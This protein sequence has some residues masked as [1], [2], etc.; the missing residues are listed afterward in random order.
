VRAETSAGES[1]GKAAGS[2]AG[3]A[4]A[5]GSG[6]NRPV[7]VR[8]QE[9]APLP[10]RF[11]TLQ[12][13]SVEGDDEPGIPMFDERSA[14]RRAVPSS[15]SL[16]F[17]A[18]A[19]PPVLASFSGL[20]SGDG[21]YDPPDPEIA[22]GNGSVVEM[23]NSEIRIW[24]TS[25]T[26]RAT[27]STATFFNSPSGDVTDPRIVYDPASGRWF[28]TVLDAGEDTV[29]LGISKTG[30]PNGSW[31]VYDHDPGLCADQPTLGVS[32]TLV[33][34]GY[35]GFPSPCRQSGEPSY[36]GG[37][38]YVYNKSQLLSGTTAYFTYWNPNPGYSPVSAVKFSSDPATAVVLTDISSLNVLSF[39]GLPN[40]SVN[41]SLSTTPIGIRSLLPPPDADQANSS[42]PINTGDIRFH[43]AAM[44]T[45]TGTTWLSANDGCVPQGDSTA[46]SCLRIIALRN[47]GDALDFDVAWNG[48]DL[49]Y[50][51]ISPA[52]AGSA[53]VVNGFSSSSTDASVGAFAVNP[54]GSISASSTIA[55][56][57][58]AHNNPR[59][60]DY[61]G[62]APD[63]SG[64][65][66][67]VGETGQS[68]SGE[69]YDW[70]TAV[71]HVGS[72]GAAPPPPPAPPPP[73]PPPP[74]PPPPPP[75]L[76]PPHAHALASSGQRG[77]VAHLRYLVSDNSGKTR[78][79][80]AVYERSKVVRRIS[81][82]LS[83]SRANTIYYVTWRIPSKP[84]LP[85]K[86]CVIAFDAAS[87]PSTQ[88]CARITAYG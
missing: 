47:G 9:I 40:Q 18:A 43:S 75:D 66:W 49:F 27:Y 70:G 53:L 16:S 31:W 45:S 80:I 10:L 15:R 28:A 7:L 61:F 32:P 58:E 41:A 76:T 2:F 19:A 54:D 64:G 23:V 77:H 8:P 44:D 48:G 22:V 68:V 39:S 35:G 38:F 36:L 82:V 65:A 55:N 25:G 12:P 83:I 50:P 11:P 72:V 42:T 52:S 62:A 63:G 87:N 59:F 85:L 30:D 17:G 24:T 29:R 67:V 60:G 56:G 13:S 6:S 84:T 5:R 26:L 37:G 3:V 4:G 14:D 1:E 51:A 34:V 79:H 81:T 73:A 78:E 21:A 33:V 20:S 88:S 74:A 46:R 86:F 69:T 57:N 71:A